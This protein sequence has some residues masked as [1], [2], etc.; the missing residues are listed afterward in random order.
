M[1]HRVPFIALNLFCFATASCLA[2]DPV[3]VSR[4]EEQIRPLLLDRCQKCH[5]GSAPKGGLRLDSAEG[6][7]RGGESG[8]VI[9]ARAEDSRLIQAI[10]HQKGLKKMPPD[11]KLSDAQIAELVAWV[12][13]GAIWPKES[14]PSTSQT[15][16]PI[17]HWSFQPVPKVE[18][19]I[20]DPDWSSHP[21]DRFIAAK[22][23][24]QQVQP[25]QVANERTLLRRVYFDLI[26]L[27]PQPNEV[28]AFLQ[29]STPHAFERVVDRLLG[30]AQYG[31]RWGRYWLDVARYADTAGDNA[32]YPVPEARLYRDYVI[33]SFNRDKPYDQFVR[34]Q[35]AGDI[36]ASEGPDDD[37]AEGVIAT[38]FLGL[39]RRYATAPYEFWHLSLEDSIDT[40]GQAFMGLTLRCARCHD[41]KYDPITTRDYYGLYGIFESTQY[42]WAGG[43]EFASKSFPRQ[44]F[45]PLVPDSVAKP[46][47]EAFQARLNDMTQQIAAIERD[48][49]L[50]KSLADLNKRLADLMTRIGQ[51][52]ETKQT[53]TEL[54]QDLASTTKQRDDVQQQLQNKLTP[55]R[56]EHRNLQRIGVPS[57]LPLAYAV[58]EGTVRP[59]FVQL[60]GEPERKGAE[61]P[62]GAIAVL[63]NGR[64][65]KI[66]DA[67]SGR[68]QLAEWLTTSEHPLT[69]RVMV[70]RI[71]QHHFGQGLVASPS[72]FGV[73]GARP[74]HPELLDWLAG[75]FV[76]S[77]WSI[78]AMH[79]LI[80]S[81]KTWQLASTDDAAN[82]A[83][84][85]ENRF[86][87]RHDRCRLDAEA[88]R[89]A[90]MR[91]SGRLNLA[92][93]GTHPF[94]P[95]TD[96]GYTQ[97]NQFR[98][99]YPATYRS[100]YL[101]TQRLQ[102]HP[103]LALFDGPDPNTTTEKRTTATV[104]LQALY[105]MN[106]PDIKIEADAFARRLLD[107]AADETVRIQYAYELAFAR[108]ASP[109]E[110]VNALRFLSEYR[111]Q[112]RQV[113]RTNEVEIEAWTSYARVLL[114]SNEFFY[115]D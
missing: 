12:E 106:S 77:G 114:T 35:L 74:T 32:D 3:A 18:P 37:Y 8:P 64:S 95:V 68:R 108:P 19:P 27:P 91:T 80:L 13:A 78:K 47:Q 41:H 85:P 110:I 10:R 59:T 87:W 39:S 111:Q 20:G 57:D 93:P 113:G 82:S 72:N 73:R 15:A 34:E 30:S 11:G 14:T 6:I 96:W 75:E 92:R 51:L 62:R 76:R 109:D 21:I 53:T 61:V 55:L 71:W 56:T 66:P 17:P 50:A 49:P 36:L 5:S 90:M 23:P 60:R 46:K 84:D 103:F 88:I 45:V 31:E 22:W 107:V 102:R 16:T 65:L 58:R 44:H 63:M 97:H 94:P 28:A 7:R 24:E 67:E 98:A 26:G 42:P 81:S 70:N 101:M 89:D 112:L 52:K 83:R 33:D 29:D 100:V 79:R 1:D 104:P 4:F 43:E 105:L 99:V 25:V 48:D 115:V 9:A 38:T 40:V 69:A 2:D 86:Y 54:D